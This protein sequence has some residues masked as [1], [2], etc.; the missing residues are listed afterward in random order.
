MKA[1]LAEYEQ[2]LLACI[3]TD[4]SI[5]DEFPIT[6]S[7]FTHQDN[8]KIFEAIQS[9][10]ARGAVADL[11]AQFQINAPGF[12]PASIGKS[13]EE[14]KAF[15][16]QPVSERLK[17]AKELKKSIA[18]AGDIVRSGYTTRE[19][20]KA[21]AG[22]FNVLDGIGLNDIQG[23]VSMSGRMASDMALG[24][25]TGGTTFVLQGYNDAVEDYDAAAEKAGL[26][27]NANA[28]G[29][30]GIAGGVIN[31]LLEKFAVDKIV[32][33]TPVFRDIQRMAIANV[34][35]NTANVTGKKAVDAIETAAVAEIKKLTSDLKSKGIRA[36][37]RFG[38]IGRAHV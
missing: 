36:A 28:R 6:G 37:Y 19:E 38:E 4:N 7:L 15:R 13:V 12:T 18:K 23:L 26:E 24:A 17:P 32:G 27:A 5:L 16:Q 21:M 10:R 20:E 33:D 3:M 1:N 8:V 14:T 30:Y 34:L 29:L 25:M 31:G 9:I 22:Q 2:S 35:K 11:P